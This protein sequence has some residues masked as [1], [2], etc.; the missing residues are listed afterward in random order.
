MLWIAVVVIVCLLVVLLQLLLNYQSR[1]QGM[2]L[3]KDPLRRRIELQVLALQEAVD[4]LRD[5][6]RPQLDELADGLA[7][8]TQLC[9]K[10]GSLLDELVKEG[11]ARGRLPD[12]PKDHEQSEGADDETALEDAL[13][14]AFKSQEDDGER[15]DIPALVLQSRTSLEGIGQHL[16]EIDSDMKIMSEALSRLDALAEENVKK[17]QPG[18]G[19]D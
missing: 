15:A 3:K 5:T 10:G 2:R 6:G 8:F 7:D 1:G 16:A 9:E 11:S 4:K 17:Q 18:Q 19:D 14:A 13:Q 12:E